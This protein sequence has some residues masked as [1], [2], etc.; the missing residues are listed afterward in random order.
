MDEQENKSSWRYDFDEEYGENNENVEE[1]PVLSRAEQEAQV[2]QTL[3]E[4]MIGIVLTALIVLLVSNLILRGNLNFSI[5][6]ILGAVTA[7]VLSFSMYRSVLIATEVPEERASGHMKR[8]AMYRM[9]IMIV[10]IGAAALL[11][12]GY[13]LFGAIIG[14]LTLKLSAFLWPVIHKYNLSLRERRK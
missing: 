14:I 3:R 11:L 12:R 4:L 8:T 2:R 5:G 9:V 13:G 6:V 1:T 10:V 7:L